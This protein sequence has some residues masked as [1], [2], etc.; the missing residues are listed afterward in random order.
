MAESAIATI[1]HLRAKTTQYRTAAR[2]WIA[3]LTPRAMTV[4][5]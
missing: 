4:N 1:R 3:S 5:E 2:V